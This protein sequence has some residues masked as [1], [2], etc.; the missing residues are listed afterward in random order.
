MLPS[1]HPGELLAEELDERGLTGSSAARALGVPQS[2]ISNI[3]RG[4]AGITADTALRLGRWLGTGPDLWLNMQKAYEVRLAE[5]TA[6]PEIVKNVKPLA[7]SH[8]A[9]TASS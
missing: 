1:I 9:A 6:G 3:L 2:R 5:A 4:G 8:A 7:P